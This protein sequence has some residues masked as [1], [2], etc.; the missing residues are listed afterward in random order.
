MISVSSSSRGAEAA[1]SSISLLS[2]FILPAFRFSELTKLF[3]NR[4]ITA[5][6]AKSFSMILKA[7]VKR[8]ESGDDSKGAP[9]EKCSGMSYFSHSSI[10]ARRYFSLFL[11]AIAIL[12]GSTPQFSSFFIDRSSRDH[13]EYSG[14]PGKAACL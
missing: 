6:T 4:S 12:A 3:D 13:S 1:I 7:A 11:K 10:R 14:K 2:S 9:L 5:F 8:C